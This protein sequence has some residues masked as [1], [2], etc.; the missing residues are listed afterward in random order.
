MITTAEGWSVLE[1]DTGYGELVRRRR[2]IDCDLADMPSHEFIRPYI[3]AGA[4]VIDV[5]AHIGSFTI[6]MCEWV[7]SLGHVFAFEPLPELFECLRCNVIKSGYKNA[8]LYEKALGDQNG[9]V[10]F[11]R[12]RENYGACSMVGNVIGHSEPKFE[13]I[14]VQ[15]ERL[16]QI[17]Y[18]PRVHFIKIDVEGAELDVLRGAQE[19]ITTDRPVLF[20]ETNQYAFQNRR[21][22]LADLLAQLSELGYSRIEFFPES[23]VKAGYQP[24]DLLAL[25]E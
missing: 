20:I 15:C 5:G 13:T 2:R 24:H 4:S 16:D 10:P 1:D 12:N 22:A 25:P 8:W 9:K 6:P 3:N 19:L 21:I 11:L 17:Q 18:L 14:E 7:G 23:W